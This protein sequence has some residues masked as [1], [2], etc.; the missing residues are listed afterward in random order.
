MMVRE[1][2]K[3]KT[4]PIIRF[5]G[6][7]SSWERKRISSLM[8]FSN[9]IN[10]PKENYGKGR[11]MISVMD[12]LSNESMSYNNIRSS[13]EVDTK[14]ENNNKVEVGDIVFVRSSEVRDEVGWAKAYLDKEY[15]L[16]SGFT[17]RGKKVSEFDALFL[18]LSINGRNRYQIER[19]AGGSTRY[20]VSQSI[21]KDLN[22]TQP[23]LI[24]Q[25]KISDLFKKIADII[26]LQ[27]QLLN[28]HKQLKKAMLQKMF[29][30][31]GESV[32]RVRFA[33][34]TDNWEQRKL[35]EV[36]PLRGGFAFQSTKFQLKG[37]PIIR[38][39]NI[40]SNERVG[41]NYVYYEQQEN[42]SK[43]S[44]PDKSA[45]LAMSGATTGKVS[46][47]DNPNNEKIYQNQRV[48]YF[49][50]LGIVNYTFISTIVKS[51]LFI[52][53]LKSV[54]VAGAQPNISSKEIDEFYFYFPT[55]KEEQTKIGD[56]FKQL[57]ETIVLHEK[58]LETYQNLKKAMLQKMFV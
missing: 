22:I 35:G 41:G 28:N 58:K 36:S 12:I 11:K 42:D 19:K 37:I 47:L 24:E 54:L 26:L 5:D 39:T 9:G 18:E 45:I 32:P 44:L 57:D 33:G 23:T 7:N 14:T 21:L 30:Q 25:K 46:V 52:N 50:D 6:F 53:Q 15:A 48:G 55:E 2:N 49:K 51:N 31:K 8:V 29:P 10:A 13:V 40:L 38:I 56:F 34:F 27:K 20:N 1:M 4:M 3:G 43:Y 16:F 17:I